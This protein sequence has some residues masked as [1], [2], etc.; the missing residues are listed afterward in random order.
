MPLFWSER[1]PIDLW[2]DLLFC[3]D[4]KMVVDLSL[5]SGV[6]ARAAM[7]RDVEYKG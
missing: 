2:I 4:A 3:L 5:G 6:A 1:K 7:H